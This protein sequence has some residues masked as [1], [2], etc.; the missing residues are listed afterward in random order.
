MPPKRSRK[1]R[2][3][4]VRPTKWTKDDNVK[5]LLTIMHTSNPELGVQGWDEIGRKVLAI[6]NQK[7]T[8]VA[9]K[10][11]YQKLRRIFLDMVASLPDPPASLASLVAQAAQDD[12]DDEY[13][14]DSEDSEDDEDYEDDPQ[15]AT[16]GR[17]RP[18]MDDEDEDYSSAAKT[19]KARV[20]KK[21]TRASSALAIKKNT[22]QDWDVSDSDS[23]NIPLKVLP[24]LRTTR[25][26]NKGNYGFVSAMDAYDSDNAPSIS[27]GPVADTSSGN[28]GND[29]DDI[30][31]GAADATDGAADVTDGVA[32]VA[33]GNADD[34]AANDDVD[35]PLPIESD[36]D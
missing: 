20:L 33:E 31:D 4:R 28:V 22:A 8:K 25:N 14:E 32:D 7:Y 2:A 26:S 6:F 29:T 36:S 5:L 23:D 17:K 16:K 13:D 27:G 21:S 15:P 18:A 30:A 11:Q 3:K 12:E 34:G 19:T 35:D 1:G 9:A 10:H 24:K